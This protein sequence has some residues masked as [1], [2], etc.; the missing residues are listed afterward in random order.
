MVLAPPSGRL[1]G[2]V[3]DLLRR[4]LTRIRQ[5]SAIDLHYAGKSEVVP[6]CFQVYWQRDLQ[7][8]RVFEA[9][10]YCREPTEAELPRLGLNHCR[11]MSP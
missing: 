10:Y 7:P 11:Q 2:P 9:Y 5:S 1:G 6:D 4:A 3:E 8:A